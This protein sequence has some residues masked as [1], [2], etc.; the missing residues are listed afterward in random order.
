MFKKSLLIPLIII[1]DLLQQTR[2]LV[3]RLLFLYN[4]LLCLGSFPFTYITYKLTTNNKSRRIQVILTEIGTHLIKKSGGRWQNITINL[5]SA[6]KWWSEEVSK[7]NDSD[8][9]GVFPPFTVDSWDLGIFVSQNNEE[10]NSEG[11]AGL[12]ST[13]FLYHTNRLLKETVLH[14][15][16]VLT[17]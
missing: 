7:S 4:Y 10:T 1:T 15:S 6:V 17:F 5:T 11:K 9:T 3:K 16:R 13:K 12:Q 14:L 8:P 2:P